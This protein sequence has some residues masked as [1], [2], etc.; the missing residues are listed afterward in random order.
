MFAMY[1]E[2]LYPSAEREAETRLATFVPRYTT[3]HPPCI[4]A[5]VQTIKGAGYPLSY[6]SRYRC[7]H[8]P[9]EQDL[10]STSWSTWM[11]I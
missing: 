6:T 3:K 4:Y 5:T 11:F 2:T 8:G 10:L 7:N 9:R 1:K